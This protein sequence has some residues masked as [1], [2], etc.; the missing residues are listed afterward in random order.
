M[1]RAQGAH[2]P[3][4]SGQ[5]ER[6]ISVFFND[7]PFGELPLFKTIIIPTSEKVSG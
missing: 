7:S 5:P 3:P 2:P 4:P 6:K 1:V